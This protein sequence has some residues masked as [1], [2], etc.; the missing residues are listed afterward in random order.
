MSTPLRR[1]LS[2]ALLVVLIAGGCSSSDGDVATPDDAAPT[3]TDEGPTETAEPTTEAPGETDPTPTPTTAEPTPEPPA[4]TVEPDPLPTEPA[5]PPEPAVVLVD[6]A[7]NVFNI[8]PD[9]P[10]I[11][12]MVDDA[13]Q[14]DGFTDGLNLA[15]A[16]G[17]VQLQR[18]TYV[19]NTCLQPVDLGAWATEAVGPTGDVRDTAPGCF[20]DAFD[21]RERGD[22]LFHVFV[23]LSFQFRYDPEIVPAITDVLAD[24]TPVAS[25]SAFLADQA[26][27][28]SN[29]STV[30]D[31]ECFLGAIDDRDVSV[32]F[33][34]TLV[35]G[36]AAPV[37]EPA[38]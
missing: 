38:P 21:D 26:E 18:L 28:E 19:F 15:V 31:R 17:D 36:L 29:Y 13:A 2:V 25:V 16:L 7:R 20:A 10:S 14:Y 27:A 4:P 24:C 6:F 23:A 22:A 35:D 5:E 37:T 1:L 12:C 8:D 33:W 34:T 11:E 3:D 30:V 9:E 32:E